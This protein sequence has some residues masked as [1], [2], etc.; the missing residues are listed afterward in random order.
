MVVSTRFVPSCCASFL[1][2][3]VVICRGVLCEITENFLQKRKIHQLQSSK[4]GE[5]SFTLG[6]KIQ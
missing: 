5:C 3:A 1:F 6:N 4:I 2:C